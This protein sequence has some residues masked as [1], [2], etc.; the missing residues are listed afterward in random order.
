M[1][2]ISS[3]AAMLVCSSVMS[4]ITFAPPQLIGYYADLDDNIDLVT[5]PLEIEGLV[6][7]DQICAFD[8]IEVLILNPEDGVEYIW[9]ISPYWN[10]EE[11]ENELIIGLNGWNGS[12]EVYASN[13]CGNSPLYSQSLELLPL[14]SVSFLPG[15]PYAFCVNTITELDFGNPTGGTFSGDNVV[16]QQLDLTGV[17]PGEQMLTYEV[18][19][20]NGCVSQEN[21]TINIRGE[22]LTDAYWDEFYYESC[23]GPLI[24][25]ISGEFGGYDYDWWEADF[26]DSWEDM[27]VFSVDHPLFTIEHVPESGTISVTLFNDVCGT[28]TTLTEFVEI[29]QAADPPE[30]PMLVSGENSWCSGS[31]GQLEFSLGTNHNLIYSSES[32][33]VEVDSLEENFMLNLSGDA[34][35][36]ELTISAEHNCSLSEDSIIQVEI[37]EIPE[38]TISSGLNAFCAGTIY[39]LN[40]GVPEGGVYYGN[41]VVNQELDLTQAEGEGGEETLVYQVQGENGCIGEASEEIIIRNNEIQGAFWSEFAHGPCGGPLFIEL[42]GAFIGVDYDS[43]SY[44]IP[45]SWDEVFIF[46]DDHPAIMINELNDSGEISILLENELCGTELELTNY[47]EIIG[48]AEIPSLVSEENSWCS[49]SGGTLEFEMLPEDNVIYSSASLIVDSISQEENLLLE[50]TGEAGI[51]ELIISA[52]NECG[53]SGDTLIQV[54]IFD[55]PLVSLTFG[56][57][58]LCTEATIPA[59][60]I[61]EGGELTGPGTSDMTIQS[62]FLNP[63]ES[64]DYLYT[65]IDE[66]S[67]V[68]FDSVTVFFETCVAIDEFNES[69]IRIFPNPTSDRLSITFEDNRNREI[70]LFNHQGKEVR[71]LTSLENSVII[72]TSNLVSGEYILR[73]D[74]S[75]FRVLIVK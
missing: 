13:D 49:G 21:T 68:N 2:I 46:P 74:N 72:D 62:Y 33:M 64:Y 69:S 52:E 58:T 36:H 14:P 5:P 31:G 20:E 59:V 27:T 66:N 8:S 17:E 6:I 9:G 18:Q 75:V 51:H 41:Y 60:V 22:E 40:I 35:I 73:I 19:G 45:D 3:I 39:P 43:W 37:L 30:I 32:L 50:M 23:G 26:P 34:G 53:A 4:Q 38:V 67:C 24:C 10:S 71:K 11:I 57:D 70:S 15:S 44:V 16:N 63:G 56:S 1:K 12:I 7:P 47:A 28:D 65:Y 61:P 54:E 42:A 48:A 55:L 25:G 29:L